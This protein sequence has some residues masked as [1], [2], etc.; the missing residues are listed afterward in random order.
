M[1]VYD[2][3]NTIYDGESA[4]DFFV[5]CAKRNPRLL[6]FLPRVLIVVARYKMCRITKEELFEL[7]AK[8]EAEFLKLAGNMRELTRGFWDANI[9]KIKEFYKK[10]HRSDD[11]IVSAS[12]SFLLEDV[13]ERL[14]VKNLVCS[15]MDLNTGALLELCFHD[16]K[17]QLFAKYFPDGVVDNFYTDSLNDIPMIKLAK[18]AFI[19]KGDRIKKYTD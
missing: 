15:R 14:R 10:A 18:N 6:K 12:F 5:Y 4:F 16:N 1:N 2:F 8:Y 13:V 11:V 9:H 17:P 3:D 19:V 7:V